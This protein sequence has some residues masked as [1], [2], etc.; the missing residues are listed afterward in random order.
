[1]TSPGVDRP[2]TVDRHW[3]KNIGRL[4]KI[5]TNDKQSINGRIKSFSAEEVVITLPKTEVVLLRGEIKRA[6]IEIEFNRKEKD[7]AK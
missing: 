2:L 5:T 1:M 6:I 7:G 4:V 3:R